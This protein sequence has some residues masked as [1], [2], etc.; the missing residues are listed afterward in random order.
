M[1]HTTDTNKTRQDS[2]V[3]SVL[4]LRGIKLMAARKV[5]SPQ[6]NTFNLIVIAII[7]IVIFA[8]AVYV[9]SKFLLYIY[10]VVWWYF[11]VWWVK[12]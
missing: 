9:F 1:V 5:C 11:Q 4:A 3:L 2:L 6:D 7:I 8:V 10:K 12:G